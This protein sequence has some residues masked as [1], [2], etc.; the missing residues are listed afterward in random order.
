MGKYFGDFQIDFFDCLDSTNSYLLQNGTKDKQVVVAKKQNKG[1]GRN[2]RTWISDDGNLYFSIF[3]KVNLNENIAQIS[4]IA[5][6][7]C[8]LSL[9]Q[10]N[11]KLDISLK[12][13]NDLLVKG[14][15]IAGILLESD[16]IKNAVICGIGVNNKNNPQSLQYPTTCLEKQQITIENE[17]LLKII[18][19]NFDKLYTLWQNFGFKTI[20][21]L[22]MKNCQNL[23]KKVTIGKKSGVF[24]DINE[25]GDLIL[26]VNNENLAI[27]C[28]EIDQSKN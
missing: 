10:I 21:Q 12:W 7:A 8:L 22:W 5:A 13:P 28:G 2:D 1:R 20:R 4:Y 19:E 14:K 26:K 3:L 15:K 24:V 6:C 16:N 9:K 27:N 18:L 23:N 11:E 25:D 17:D